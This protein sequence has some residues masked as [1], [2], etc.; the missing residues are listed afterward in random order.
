M[1]IHPPR[2]WYHKFR[3]LMAYRV[4]E[5]LLVSSD[6][7]AF[8]LEEDGPITDQVFREY[9]ELNLSWAPRLTH[10]ASAQEAMDLLSV[11]R[12]DL[13]ITV[14]RLADSNA[15]EF[16]QRVKN[17]HPHI[18]IHLLTFD[19][20]DVVDLPG[21][22]VP[23]TIDRTFLWSGDARLLIAMIKLAEDEKNVEED[24]RNA[25]VQVILV[26]EDDVRSY[27]TFLASLYPELLAHSQSLIA[28]GLNALHRLTRMRARPKILL[29]HTYEEALEL[30]RRYHPQLFALISD[31]CMPRAGKAQSD[32]GLELVGLVRGHHNELP[33]AVRS[34]QNDLAGQAREHNAYF[35]SKNAA[36]WLDQLRQFLQQGLGFGDFV[37][38]LPNHAEVLRSR[39]VF[40]MEKALETAPLASVLYHAERNHFSQWL[41]ARSMFELATRI[42]PRTLEE[43]D[44]VEEVRDFLVGVLRDARILEQEGVIADVPA[45]QA[46]PETRFVRIGGGSLGGKGRSIAFIRSQ[47]VSRGLN[48]RF[49]G[50]A[51]RIP[52]TMVLGTDVFDRFIENMP[53]AEIL[54]MED[55][56]AIVRRMLAGELPQEFSD[57]L[58]SALD[59]FVGPLAVRSSGLLEDS[60][61][62]P[63]AGIYATYV[64][65]NNHPDPETRFVELCNAIKAVY[66]STY[67]RDARN[68]VANTPYEIKDQQMAV[69]VQ[70]L[71]GRTWGDRFYPHI[72]GVA[73]SYN[74][75]PIGSQRADDGIAA[76]AFGLGH[77]V[78]GG[79][80]ALR[81]SPGAPSALPQ[82]PDARSFLKNAQKEFFALDLSDSI[83]DFAAT[84]GGSLKVHEIASALG[85]GSLAIAAGTYF[86]EDDVIRDV[87]STDGLP[88]VTFGNILRWNVIPL[89]EALAEILRVLRGGIGREVEIEFAVDMGDWGGEVP[90]GA[91]R[92]D[93]RLYVLQ[94]RPLATVDRRPVD[95]EID[96]IPPGELLC[97]TD[98]SLG[99]GI[100]DDIRDIVY[101]THDDIDPALTRVAQ[102]EI[103][104]INAELQAA[105]RPY[106]L[107]GPGRWG[108]SD[109]NLGIPVTWPDI[110]GARVVVEMPIAGRQVEPSQGTHFFHNITTH[111]VGYLALTHGSAGFIDRG[112]LDGQTDARELRATRHVRLPEPI[113]VLL[114]GRKGSAIVL[115]TT[116]LVRQQHALEGDA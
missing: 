105:G 91:V 13:V 7:D 99:N 60:R 1:S 49:T 35:I 58:R 114:D 63:F 88:V 50:L 52:K 56:L 20:S 36:D 70:R 77:E 79:G 44:D 110:A 51:V 116:R 10:A 5:L 14:V 15:T 31:I 69:V 104:G 16:S 82:F 30:R 6:Y 2:L 19:E 90:R 62:E 22:V 89:A 46:Q 61:F 48:N 112:W 4:R 83:V 8:V 75:Y 68:Y 43:F 39:D 23:S 27:S 111:R 24:T 21:A 38:R 54:A 85:D 28:E 102:Q 25:G 113:A 84:D 100:H 17:A 57:Q 18:P 80:A 109:P 41:L 94:A 103:R 101:V 9:S 115:K 86:P 87:L 93:P 108:S 65:P 32:A 97:R 73:Q 37:F 26:V 59:G 95:L 98:M 96:G 29:A 33:I 66:A 53:L 55:D 74:Y 72:S 40:E 3:G 12:F 78:V 64:L 107:V 71:V 106:L 11:R 81:F 76:I 92:R 34:S 45:S 42:H 47:I 67:R